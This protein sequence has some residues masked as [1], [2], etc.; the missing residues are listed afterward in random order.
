MEKN[1]TT[2]QPTDEQAIAEDP[3]M[4]GLGAFFEGIT[5][6]AAEYRQKRMRSIIELQEVIVAAL[7]GDGTTTH[8][9]DVTPD[10]AAR[11]IARELIDKDW[12]FN[13]P[14]T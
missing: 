6:R 2:N 12:E 9:P 8:M 11:W 13:P 14:P 1:T 5:Q 7:H 10:Q 4:P 3:D